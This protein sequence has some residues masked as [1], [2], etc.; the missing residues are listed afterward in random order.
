MASD[1]LENAMINHVYRNTAYTPPTA[2][3]AALYT[4]DPTDADTGTE[5]TGGSYA[6]QA[7]TFGAPVN[8]VSSNTVEVVFPVATA[9]WG[10]VTHGAIR[11][12]VTAGDLLNHINVTAELVSINNQYK[13]P[14]GS[15]TVTMT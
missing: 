6:R 11:S 3:Y 14:I 15:I 8:G 1:F 7:I 5:V 13:F 4:T 2:V 10:T 12:A 9:S